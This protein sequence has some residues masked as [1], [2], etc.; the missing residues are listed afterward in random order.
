MHQTE[1]EIAKGLI[2]NVERSLSIYVELSHTQ[3][4]YSVAVEISKQLIEA[5][6]I[7][8]KTGGNREKIWNLEE[9]LAITIA[10][11]LSEVAG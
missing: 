3:A 1:Q 6:S 10:Q 11:I 2:A 5:Y 9:K 8:V 4:K 7:F